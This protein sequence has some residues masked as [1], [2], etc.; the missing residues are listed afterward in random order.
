MEYRFRIGQND[1]RYLYESAK[2]RMEAHP[3][4]ADGQ[5]KIIQEHPH[6]KSEKEA[7]EA[8]INM[9][10]EHPYSC[11]I[12]AKFEEGD[13]G[14]FRI[15]NWWVATDDW[16]IKLAAEYIGMALMYDQTRLTKIIDN[17]I[18]IDDVVAYW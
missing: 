14:I 16:K 13:D 10:K 7:L 8:A 12:W 6:F 15:Q 1:M 9:E 2:G 4:Y 11:Q 18:Q 3:E 5:K 17:N